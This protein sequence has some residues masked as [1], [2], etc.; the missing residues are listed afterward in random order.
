MSANLSFSYHKAITANGTYFSDVKDMGMHS[1]RPVLAAAVSAY[2]N[3]DYTVT[4]QH[5][6]DNGLH[7]IDVDSLAAISS[8]TALGKSITANLICIVRL[9]V[10]A[11][12]VVAGA[13]IDAYLYWDKE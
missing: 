12:N 9:K 13:T 7:W 4:L 3:G 11:A 5:T 2:T 1:N 8:A 10:V 6:P